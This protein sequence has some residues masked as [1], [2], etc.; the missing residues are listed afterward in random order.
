MAN[1]QKKSQKKPAVFLDVKGLL[2]SLGGRARIPG[3]LR[4]RRIADVTDEQVDKWIY[5]NSIPSQHLGEVL[6]LAKLERR[7]VK[8]YRYIKDARK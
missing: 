2:Q 6:L 1:I 8:I 3:A 5:R 7:P 4:E